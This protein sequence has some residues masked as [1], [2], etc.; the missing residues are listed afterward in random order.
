MVPLLLLHLLVRDSTDYWQQEVRYAITA[1]LDEPSGVLTGRARIV[2][3][4]HSPDT[5]RDFYVHQY[6]NAFRPG[7]RWAAS[8]SVEGQDR[9]G[10]LA[11]PDYA[12][13]RITASRVGGVTARPD[14]PYAPD[15]TIA[16]WQLDAPLA[17]GDSLTADVQWQAR[18]STVPR[19]QGRAG[20]RFDFAQWY[21]KVVV[22]DRYGWEDHPL[23][24]AGE[25][26]GEF[27]TFDVT[28][29]LAADQVIGATGVPVEG[30]PGW[31]HTRADRTQAVDYQRDFYGRV[32]STCANASVEP[33][34]KCVHFHAEQ[35]HHFAFSLNPDYVYEEG[36]YGNAVVRVLYLPGDSASWGRGIAVG[37]TEGAL[38][39]LDG[40]FG[41]YQW[42]QLTNVHRIEGGG[43]EF[44]MMIMNGGASVG[45]IVHE[46]GHQYVMGQL[47]NNEWREGWLDEGFTSFQSALFNEVHTGRSGYPGLESEML[48]FDLQGWS[49]PISQASERFNDFLTYQEMIYSKAQLFYEQLRYVVGDAAMAE[50]LRTY[51]ARWKLKHVDE[52]ALRRVAEDVSHRDL[53]WLFA[54]WLHGV[55]V[56]DYRLARVTRHHLPDG[57]W[58]TTVEVER[59][60]DGWMP[61]E[62]GDRDTIYGRLEG[63]AARERLEF[64]TAREPERLM[65]DPRVRTHDWNMLNNYE[66]RAIVGS[67]EWDLR[68]DNPTNE[69]VRRDRQVRA[70]VPVAWYNDFGGFTVGLR[71][72]GN[73]FGT[74]N[75]DLVLGSFAT[76]GDATAPVGGY[77]RI[78]NPIFGQPMPHIRSTF[79]LWAV[80]GRAGASLDVD[81][82]LKQHPGYGADPHA[83]FDAIWMATTGLGYLDRGLWDDGGT[84]EA[85]PR[86]ETTV[87]RG[88]SVFMAR[89]AGHLGV[90]YWN[91]GPGEE[92]G[93][94]YDVAAFG[95]LWGETS[96][97][98]PF[99]LGTRMGLRVFGGAYL[100][101]A[102]PLAQRRIMVAG[103]DPYQTF[104]NPFLRSQGA[105]L[106]RPDFQYHEPGDANL[107]AFRP[108]LGGRW[109]VALNAE[110]ARVVWQRKHG[111][112]RDLSVGGFADVGLVDSMATFGNA[113]AHAYSGV[114]DVGLGV[115]SRQQLGE[116]E[117]MLRVEFPIEMNEPNLA[118]DNRTS[119]EAVAFRW[120]VSL[121]ASF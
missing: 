109:A 95:R 23:Y 14:Y 98:A 117:W 100:S 5:L 94:R 56:I 87:E 3:V 36:R 101:H 104:T 11:D 60:G 120:L 79:A 111:L 71:E 31:E 48:W 54:Q 7:S 50:I 10:H 84:I 35:T 88:T 27:A 29:D 24:P 15:S 51:F 55:P 25:F 106:V 112:V 82:S 91:P 17:P 69:T 114:H 85:G 22:Y 18:P 40:L 21:P 57:R 6:L 8:D 77:L 9:F 99:W 1:R 33:G 63:Q 4:N 20:R 13:E 32:P 81:R 34:R 70:F 52:D 116:L 49:E 66:R 97:R 47:A 108:D 58:R 121:R 68:L 62:V 16:H 107:R 44:P 26:Y 74:Y 110:I 46:S 115:A 37:R 113:S 89:L 93:N 119:D 86:V 118:A 41:P 105:L 64:V 39:W 61:V 53:K 12:F 76:R 45:L 2:Y 65:L 75:K 103:A 80:E 42:P 43:T 83:G 72:R 96:L 102:D 67:G 78:T 28:L 73:Y 30:D 92:S 59:R 90:A 19:R 38:G